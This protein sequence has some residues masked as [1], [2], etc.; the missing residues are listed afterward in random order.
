MEL[1][2]AAVFIRKLF[3]YLLPL[4]FLSVSVYFSMRLK[5]QPLRY[6]GYFFSSSLKE[7]IGMLKE[8]SLHFNL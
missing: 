6:L 5:F 3:G 4:I 1:L 2:G 8:R 7:I